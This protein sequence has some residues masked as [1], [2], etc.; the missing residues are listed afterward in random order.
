MPNGR[1]DRNIGLFGKAGQ[2]RLRAANVAIAGIGGIGTHVVQ[3][4]ALLGVGSLVL[5]DDEDLDDSNRNRYV[6]ARHDD[7]VPGTPKVEIG[8]RIVISIDPDI[9][10]RKVRGDLLSDESLAELIR[11]DYVVGCLDT[12]GPR[13]FLT[14]VC[15]AFAIPYIDAATDILSEDRQRYGGRVCCA[16]NGNGC[17]VCMGVL[18]PKEAE[19]DLANPETAQDREA[20]YGVPRGALRG[21]TGPAVVSLNGL[22]ASVATTEF[23]VGVTGLRLPKRLLTYRGDLGTVAASKDAPYEGCYYCRGMRGQ[24]DAVDLWRFFRS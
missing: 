6:G 7:P 10:V 11:S 1:F 18:D 16:W 20:I 5:I 15:S 17:L 9:A 23:M 12:D 21:R 24:R 19:M 4:L 13:L 2:A 14:E 3:Q 22:V 8:N